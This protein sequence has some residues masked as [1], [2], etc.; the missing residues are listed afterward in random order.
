MWRLVKSDSTKQRHINNNSTMNDKPECRGN[1][2][3]A[4]IAVRRERDWKV[5]ESS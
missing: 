4:V 2:Q 3:E 5:E 1:M